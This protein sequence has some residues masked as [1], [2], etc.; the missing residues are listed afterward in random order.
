M[1]VGETSGDNL[2][3]GLIQA[4][5]RRGVEF[6]VFGICGP[7]MMQEGARAMYT[8][9]RINAIGLE[10]LASRVVKILR[11]RSDLIKE[12]LRVRPDVFV[13]IDA[14]DFN[15]EV[16][17]RLTRAGIPAIQYVCPT[18]WA[19]RAYR[20]RKIKRAAAKVLTI[21]PFE[22]DLLDKHQIPHS[23]VGHP[24]AD[25]VVATGDGGCRDKFGFAAEDTVVAML[26]GSRMVEVERL[27][28][29]FI[30]VAKRL[31]SRREGMRIIVPAATSQIRTFLERLVAKDGSAPPMRLV[32]G[33]SLDA[34]A[35]SDVV[36]LASG[37]AA[38]EAALMEKPLVVAY[39]V[40]MKTYLLVK[41]LGTVKHY[42]ILN[43][44]ADGPVVPEY[45]QGDA[46]A[47]NLSRE[48]ERLLDD[49]PYRESM[50][51]SFAEIR[52]RLKRSASDGAASEIEKV[53]RG[54]A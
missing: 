33:Q 18:I 1:V 7:A 46:T 30:E 15:L 47:E 23:Y 54:A 31:A 37:T 53:L 52:A 45:M 43:H 12:M 28:G 5:R 44:L 22:G 17:S 36:L 19:W 9:D 39:K 50:I 49:A 11:C 3:A 40:S 29:I 27:S 24:L 25:S 32:E 41:A 42:S 34:M 35:C 48:L 16:E 14:P 10:G 38:L 8:L 26:P 2:G 20:A 51:A 4:L 21:Y 13:G 6:E